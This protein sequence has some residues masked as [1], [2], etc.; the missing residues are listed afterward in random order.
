MKDIAIYKAPKYSTSPYSQEA[1]DIYSIGDVF[2]ASL[3][4]V[5]EPELG[6]GSSASDISQYPLEDILDKYCVYVSDFYEE[7]N[8][9]NSKK[10]Y[11]EFAGYDKDDISELLQ[12]IGHHVYNKSIEENGEALEA[13]IIE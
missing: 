4:F 10:C 2:V 11:L 3:S 12:I 6:E 8:T 9:N 5:Q 7:L 13:L 1:D